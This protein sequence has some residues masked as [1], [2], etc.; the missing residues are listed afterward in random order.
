MFFYSDSLNP[1]YRPTNL[2]ADHSENVEY[3]D[4]DFYAY[5]QRGSFTVYPEY[6][7]LNHWHEDVE[8]IY[9]EKGRM[10]YH[11][12]ADI[13]P[14][15]RG[16]GIF[17]NAKHF[18]YGS[19]AEG[20]TCDFD[21][22]ILHPILLCITSQIE[23]EF[24]DPVTT[25]PELPY[26]KLSPKTDWMK[27]ILENIR[28]MYAENVDAINK[29]QVQSRFYHIWNTLYQHMPPRRQSPDIRSRQFSYL[30]DM[31]HYIELHHPEKMT[32]EEIAA[33]GHMSVSKCYDLFHQFLGRTP[34]EYLTKF[35]LDQSIQLM[36]D[37]DLSM[38]EI[39]G[40]VGFTGS[41]YYASLF[42]KTFGCSP[43]AYR[44]KLRV[45]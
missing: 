24:V 35:R 23:R 3:N 1:N 18:H 10:E 8:F 36:T 2:R 11:V 22:C 14:L 28:A 7:A 20:A 4:P 34:L 19:A 41:S 5:I 39:T 43:S 17:V 45:R 12:D 37:T 6:S 27:D 44:K 30:K 32:V 31:V 25:H 42:R 9:V 16:E 33:A 21:C 38:T 15:S 29:L 40:L 26:I 13:I